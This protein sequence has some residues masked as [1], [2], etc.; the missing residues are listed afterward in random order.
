[1]VDDY[2]KQVIQLTHTVG[3]LEATIA[4]L[5]AAQIRIEDSVTLRID[6]LED[7]LDNKLKELTQ[8]VGSDGQKLARNNGALTLGSYL[9][10][11][12]IMLAA[13]FIGNHF[14]H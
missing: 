1:M 5:Q 12:I 14:S 10:Q 11:A 6:R 3:R 8:V 2:G 7:N 13:A 9:L 4:S